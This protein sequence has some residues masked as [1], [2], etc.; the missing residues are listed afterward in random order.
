[1]HAHVVRLICVARSNV[2]IPFPDAEWARIVLN[3][4]SVDTELRESLVSRSY[5]VDGSVFVA[6]FRYGWASAAMRTA[7]CAD[8]PRSSANPRMLRTSVTSFWEMF[9]LAAKTIAQFAPPRNP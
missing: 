7:H 4:L 1:M 9:T 3:T 8:R 6:Q 2:R 5:A